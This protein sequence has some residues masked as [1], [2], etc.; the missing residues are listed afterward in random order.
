MEKHLCI[1][2]SDKDNVAVAIRDLAKG[3]EVLPGVVTAVD[4]PI[5]GW[6]F[7]PRRPYMVR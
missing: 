7:D 6:T 1:K 2:I 5:G 4:I 3:T